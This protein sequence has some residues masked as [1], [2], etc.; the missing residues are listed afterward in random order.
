MSEFLEYSNVFVKYDHI[1]PCGI[2]NIERQE[3][4]FNRISLWS[5]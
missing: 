4:I 3:G 5:E 2:I 1:L